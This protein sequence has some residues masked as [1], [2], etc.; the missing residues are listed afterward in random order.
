M[1]SQR[2]AVW[3]NKESKVGRNYKENGLDEG[4]DVLIGSLLFPVRKHGQ[5]YPVHKERKEKRVRYREVL[6]WHLDAIG[7]EERWNQ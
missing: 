6:L 4:H 3:E 2:L 1:V 7:G 5:M